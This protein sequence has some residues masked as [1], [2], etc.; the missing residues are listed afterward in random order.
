ME[1]ALGETLRERIKRGPMPIDEAW[2]RVCGVF[3]AVIFQPEDVQLA[4]SRFTNSS[5]KR[6]V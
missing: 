4:L 1:L 6:R 5:T 2:L 3:Q